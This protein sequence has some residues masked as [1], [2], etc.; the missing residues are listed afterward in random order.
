MSKKVQ[1]QHKPQQPAKKTTHAH[2]KLGL[3][4]RLNEWLEARDKKVFYGLLILSTLFSLLL[5][6]SKVT[7]GGDDSSYIERAWSFLKDGKFPYFQGP[8]YPVFLSLFVKMFG[9]NVVA[10]KFVSVFCQLGFVW[11]TYLTFRKRIPYLVLFALLAFISV[12]NFIQYYAS[13]TFTETFF[14]F[15]QSICLFITFKIID[16]IKSEDSLVDGFK[17]NYKQWLLFG[18]MFVILTISKSIA[19]VTIAGVLIY[20]VLNKNYK[21][22][23]YAIVAFAVF[24]LLY[25]AIT[26]ALFGRNETN[27]LEMM[28]RVDLYKPQGAHVDFSGMINRFFT[29]FNTY[30]S[31]HMY[32]ILNLRLLSNLNILDN[33][34]ISPLPALSYLS[35]IILGIFT[36][37]SYKRNKF[38]FFSSIYLIVLVAGVFF[39]VQ[40]NNMQS[41]LIIIAMPL[42]FLVLFYGVYEIARRNSSIQFIFVLFSVIMLFVSIGKSAINAKQNAVALKKNM[43]G[44]MFYGYTPDWENFLKMS[45]YCADSLPDSSRV[46]SRKPAMSFIYGHGKEFVGQFDAPN[47]PNADSVLMGWKKNNVKYIILANLRQ[48][49]KKN[50]GHVINNIHRM[51]YPITKQYPQKLKLV[52]TIGADEN[53]E[54]YQIDY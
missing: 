36:F 20:F 37:I 27:Q 17:Q 4:D 26:T 12:N 38:I 30:I 51:L 32:R 46:L 44:D 24:R 21:Q 43:A 22:V 52:K 14:L 42:I 8:G 13:Q 28:L 33:D 7:L 25:F 10:L 6:D 53:C 11:V 49:P 19:F 54:L 39:G 16:N 48:N 9:I 34:T 5:F 35:T 50:N 40:E 31:W 23:L 1:Q 47:N 41:R 18:L 45:Q 2:S 15:I 29:N 3:L